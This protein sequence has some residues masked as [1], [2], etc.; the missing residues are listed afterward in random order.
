MWE[1]SKT[2]KVRE[3]GVLV[4]EKDKRQA[5][6]KCSDRVQKIEK[7]SKKE[8]ENNDKSPLIYPSSTPPQ[9]FAP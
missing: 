8:I 1:T 4:T 2:L 3:V 9:S 6:M 7:P 5:L